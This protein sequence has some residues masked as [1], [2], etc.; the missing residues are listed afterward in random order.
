MRCSITHTHTHRHTHAA[1]TVQYVEGGGRKNNNNCQAFFSLFSFLNRSVSVSVSIH[2]PARSGPDATLPHSYTSDS[3]GWMDEWI[4]RREEKEREGRRNHSTPLKIKEQQVLLLVLII[5]YCYV[6]TERSG[7]GG[8]ILFLILTLVVVVLISRRRRVR[9]CGCR[10]TRPS[11]LEADSHRHGK[12]KGTTHLVIRIRSWEALKPQRAT[13][14][15]KRSCDLPI[16]SVA[17]N[18]Y[19]RNK[20]GPKGRL[21]FQQG[22]VE[23]MGYCSSGTC[24]AWIKLGDL[25]GARQKMIGRSGLNRRSIGWYH[26]DIP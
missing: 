3:D 4:V 9:T 14:N 1:N 11:L 18:W 25:T 12:G 8:S 6:R 16:G 22:Q 17:I 23:K 7:G 26:W 21:I 2:R 20:K 13:T 10:S 5:S 24:R 19:G 15:K